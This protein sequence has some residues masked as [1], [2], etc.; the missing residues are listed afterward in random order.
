MSDS[1]NQVQNMTQGSPVRLLLRFML[2]VLLGQ[3]VQQTYNMADSIIVGRILGANALAAVGASTSVQFMILGFCSGICDGFAIPVAQQFG[4]GDYG[5]MR[6]FLYHAILLTL[7]ISLVLTSVTALLTGQ[8]IHLL[9]VSDEIAGN[10]TLYLRIIF[11]GLPFTLFYNLQASLLRAVGNSRI[12]FLFLLTSSIINIF[13]DL[14]C[15]AVLDWG[16]AGAAI[17]TITSQLLSGFLCLV[18][19]WRKMQILHPR[20]ENRILS[21]DIAAKLLVMGLPM[22]L[23]FSIT[24]IGSMVMQSSN[25][26]LGSIYI[27]GYT[28]GDRVEQFVM[29]PYV[30][31]SSSV[32]TYVGQNFG[33]GKPDRIRSGVRSAALLGLLYGLIFGSLMAL[34]GH[35]TASLF[36][37][38]NQ[39]NSG[40]ILGIASR[41]LTYV[42]FMFFMV[43]PVNVFRPAL[44]GMGYPGRAVGSGVIEMIAR[45]VFA[46]TMVPRLGFTAICLTHQTAWLTAGAYVILVYYSVMKRQRVI[47]GRKQADGS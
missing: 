11:L 16:C 42:G 39:A 5:K 12:P 17:A 30:A 38:A 33:A 47:K 46:L 7:G 25:N 26:A 14:F 31:L 24:G 32:A 36:L 43:T 27:A 28:A 3:L 21:G 2:P 18:Y 6:T 35:T 4:A 1:S 15:V 19:I 23:Q 10:A 9:N 8:I 37:S 22:G 45:T 29:C 13:L 34:T 44:Q 41:F 40:R 20:R